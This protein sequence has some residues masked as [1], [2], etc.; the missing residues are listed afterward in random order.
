MRW[1]LITALLISASPAAAQD[2]APPPL[3]FAPPPLTPEQQAAVVKYRTY[4]STLIL[5]RIDMAEV[6]SLV[7][8]AGDMLQVRSVKFKIKIAPSGQ[9][10]SRRI[11]TSCGYEPLDSVFLG[12]LD[13][14]K[15]FSPPPA[16]SPAEEI[17]ATFTIVT[18]ASA[19][20][21]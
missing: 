20:P 12:A 6:D 8:Q 15:P 5:S 14:S 19:P 1:T 9:L 13:R 10:L 21:Q 17:D 4:L 2:D 16:F 11:D 3:N 18:A 7:K